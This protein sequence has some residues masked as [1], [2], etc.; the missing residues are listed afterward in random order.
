MPGSWQAPAFL[1]IDHLGQTERKREL[2]TLLA[3]HHQLVLSPLWSAVVCRIDNS[4]IYFSVFREWHLD[5]QES[6]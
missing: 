5:D 1:R 2:D 4:Y 3:D 6:T